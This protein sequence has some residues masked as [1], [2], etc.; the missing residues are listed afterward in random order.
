MP[1]LNNCAY[2]TLD[3]RIWAIDEY[4]A[5]D[6]TRHIFNSH[7]RKFA[8]FIQNQ[9]FTLHFEPYCRSQIR[10]DIGLWK[11]ACIKK[12][13]NIIVICTPEYFIEDSKAFNDSKKSHS[14]LEIDGRLL[15]QIAYSK[16]NDR[17]TPVVLDSKRPS[18]NEVPFW[19]APLVTYSWPSG[20]ENLV[21][22]L[23]GQPR[24]KLPKVDR[25]VIKPIVIN[26]PSQSRH[27]CWRTNVL[28]GR[29]N[30]HCVLNIPFFHSQLF[31]VANFS[32]YF[33]LL[34][35]LSWCDSTCG[36]MK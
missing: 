27:K 31:I 22:C 35:I 1:H 34:I 21:L 17:I 28:S 18:R 26:F 8:D 5:I 6:N 11:E 9:G 16:Q 32:K 13:K 10:G 15:R 25:I 33:L 7:L 30:Q 29:Y 36:L 20:Q 12:S 14:K 24:Y 2:T 19:L 3:D 23:D 4:K